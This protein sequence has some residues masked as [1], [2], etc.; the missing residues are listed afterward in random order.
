MSS[1]SAARL[2][3]DASFARARYSAARFAVARVPSRKPGAMQFTRIAGACPTAMQ[4]VRGIR[5]ALETAY[6]IEEPEGD[7]PATDAMLTMRPAPLRF[8]IGATA[9]MQSMGPVRLTDRIFCHSSYVIASR[10]LKGIHLL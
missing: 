2:S 1:L 7:R 9:L 3:S 6:G 5:P 10:S 4:R 8:M